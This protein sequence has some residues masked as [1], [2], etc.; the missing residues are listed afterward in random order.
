MELVLAN[1]RNRWIVER[2]A[3]V[4]PAAGISSFFHSENPEKCNCFKGVNERS[5]QVGMPT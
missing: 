1:A 4:K 5:L 2:M 3:S